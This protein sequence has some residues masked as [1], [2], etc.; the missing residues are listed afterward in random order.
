MELEIDII[1]RNESGN[2][3]HTDRPISLRMERKVLR[4][5]FEESWNT[6]IKKE[7]KKSIMGLIK[8]SN[9][10]NQSSTTQEVKK[11]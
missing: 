11:E 7:I 9:S 5:E 8:K 6:T 3:I 1:L 10:Q 4:G 2:E